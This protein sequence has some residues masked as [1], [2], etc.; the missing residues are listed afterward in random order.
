MV[1]LAQMLQNHPLLYSRHSAPVNV[2][3]DSIL[4]FN[5]TPSSAQMKLMSFTPCGPLIMEQAPRQFLRFAE[6]AGDPL[7][8]HIHRSPTNKDFQEP[9]ELG[10]NI[11]LCQQGGSNE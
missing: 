4:L 7:I 6:T 1:P 8:P 3:E 9:Q 5:L 2:T 10:Q 11:P